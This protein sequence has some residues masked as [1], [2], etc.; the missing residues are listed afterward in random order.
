MPDM[1]NALPP[2]LALA[3]AVFLLIKLPARLFPAIAVAGAA[4][5]LLRAMAL[6]NLKVPGIGAG[7]L[8]GLAMVV[9]GA[10]SWRKSGSKPLVTAA[11][12]VVLLGLMRL[13]R[14]YL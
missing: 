9:G 3:A 6:L 1:H 12:I 14:V 13:F 7:A 4:L 8:F 5:E 11:T 10:G 2:L